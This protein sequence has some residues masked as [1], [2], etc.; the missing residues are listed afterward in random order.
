M[1]EYTEKQMEQR[2]RAVARYTSEKVDRVNC[3]FPRGTKERIS[4]TGM[5]CNA[6]IKNVCW[7]NW[8]E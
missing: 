5:S 1:V 4:R 8:I 2:R 3:L 7:K 6:F